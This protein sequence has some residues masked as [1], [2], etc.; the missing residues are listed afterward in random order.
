MQNR[1][2][3]EVDGSKQAFNLLLPALSQGR[4][5]PRPDHDFDRFA[6]WSRCCRSTGSGDGYVAYTAL[7]PGRRRAAGRGRRRA[8]RAAVHG[9]R[10]GRG[11]L[12]V[13]EQQP[14][15]APAPV[16]RRGFLGA[17]GA[18]SAGLVVGAAAGGAVG[19][20]RGEASGGDAVPVS[21]PA[22]VDFHGAAPGRHRHAGPGPAGVRVLRRHD[23]SRAELAAMLAT[24]AAAS[25]RMDAGQPVG[26]G[27]RVAA[28]AADRHRRG[29]RPAPA[30]A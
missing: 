23:R 8:R 18:G 28:G 21:A 26:P 27:R 29:P 13:P 14:T 6:S 3:G 22:S 16:S 12:A 5:D 7:S 24:W 19:Y 20:A 30:R 1:P 10:Q 11:R 4:P 25:R 15:A 2:A 9:R 17:L